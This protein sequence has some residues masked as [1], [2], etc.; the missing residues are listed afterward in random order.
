MTSNMYSPPTTT[1]SRVVLGID[2]GTSR[3]GYGAIVVR[4]ASM[5]RIESGLLRL[6]SPQGPA[7]FSEIAAGVD[8]L[9]NR[10]APDRV[11]VETIFFSKNKRTALA[12]AHARGAVLAALAK[13]NAVIVE[14]N[15][16]TVKVS[17]AGYGNASKAA[18]ARLVGIHLG[19][20]TEN[21]VDDETDALAIAIAAASYHAP[22]SA[23]N[24]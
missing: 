23:V 5:K 4:G 21:S 3:V 13:R 2:P 12:V 1:D 24:G 10:L 19:I 11:G 7:R 8:S 18:V 20:S 16:A 9:I 14:I 6:S 15:P 22:P 17:V